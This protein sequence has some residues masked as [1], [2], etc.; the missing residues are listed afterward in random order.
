[1]KKIILTVVVALGAGFAQVE[2]AQAQDVITGTSQV[3]KATPR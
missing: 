2:T 1:M 3:D